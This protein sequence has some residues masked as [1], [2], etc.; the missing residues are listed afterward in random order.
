MLPFSSGL[1]AK[2]STKAH[3]FRPLRKISGLV[4]STLDPDLILKTIVDKLPDITGAKGCTILL[5]HPAT[6][7]PEV[8]VASGLFSNKLQGRSACVA[9]SA[10]KIQSLR[11]NKNT[12]TTI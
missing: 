7:R 5:L 11:C 1:N 8:T 9:V 12:M 6:N 4:N 3:F 2:D 10:V